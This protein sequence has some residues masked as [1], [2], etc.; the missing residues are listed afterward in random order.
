MDAAGKLSKAI[1]TME[2]ARG[3]LYSFHQL[4]G[5]VDLQL[6]DACDALEQAG[7]RELAASLRDTV[8]GRNVITDRWS[9]Q[10]VEDYDD[11]YYTALRDAEQQV[12]A[13]LMA[14][15]RHVF[16]AELKQREINPARPEQQ[17]GPGVTTAPGHGR[18][19]RGGR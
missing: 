9:F 2:R 15:R 18:P 8:V 10:I 14:G 1:E 17:P 7:H 4:S 12:R 3:H 6:Q 19:I 13:Q 11:G 16:E 5:T